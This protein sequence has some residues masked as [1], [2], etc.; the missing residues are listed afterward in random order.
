MLAVKTFLRAAALALAVPAAL[1]ATKVVESDSTFL[2]KA[3]QANAAE[4]KVSQAAQTR[5]KDARIKAFADRMVED[6]SDNNKRLEALAQ[7]KDVAVKADPDPDH[8][9]KIGTLQKLEG[10]EF[11]RAYARLMVEDHRAA[12]ALFEQAA[13]SA[14]DP[15]IK[16]FA[17]DTLPALREHATMAEA[18]PK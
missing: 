14:S 18:L 17:A 16:R 6:H 8:M 11:E 5:A 4:V 1:A 3:A 12:V 7:Q 9:L 15:D 10:A 2:Q 13:E